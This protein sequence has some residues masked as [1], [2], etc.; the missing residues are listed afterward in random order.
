[1]SEKLNFAC[2]KAVSVLNECSTKYGLYAS[3]GTQ[4]YTQ[5][6]ARDSC[7]SMIGASFHTSKF[8][9]VFKKSLLTLKLK[10]SKNGQIPNAVDFVFSIEKPVTYA[11][12]DS[13][14][15][16]ILGHYFYRKK[17]GDD[18][19]K[20]SFS[21][22]KMAI[23]WVSCQDAG[24]DM[25]PE[26]LPTTDWQDCFPHRYGHT[27][28]TQALYF[29]CL[30]ALG[31][32]NIHS[33]KRTINY[34]LWDD[35]LGYYLPWRWKDHGKYSEKGKWFDS[36]GNVLAI[37]FGVAEKSKAKRIVSFI[38]NN[39]VDRPYPLRAIFPTIEKNSN[40]WHDYFSSSLAGQPNQYLN[41]GIWPFIGGFYIAALEELNMHK[42]AFEELKVL[43]DA[44]KIGK[45]SEWE[46]N[47]WISPL[48][49]TPEGGYHQAWSAGSYLL[50]F[51][52]VRRKKNLLKI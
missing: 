4:G 13:S 51:E 26:Q 22:I 16:Y 1:M 41:G 50:A 28:N 37:V 9:E 18:L 31:K 5:V 23:D 30:K 21:S 33:L 39:K 20:K 29:A 3:G 24:E 19:W 46:F 11:T 52:C 14:L 47:E 35:D 45:Y 49:G 8:K 34:Y 42:Q 10:Q 12:I 15:W 6:W 27:I 36:F 43:A 17:F 32:K 38:R 40:D 2:E 25:M 44:N 48:S 7:I